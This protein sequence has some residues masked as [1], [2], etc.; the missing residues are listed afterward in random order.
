MDLAPFAAREVC[1][2][3]DNAPA[4]RVERAKERLRANLR[5][6]LPREPPHRAVQL[7]ARR[8]VPRAEDHFV[9]DAARVE[10]SQSRGVAVDQRARQIELL[11]KART[12]PGGADALGSYDRIPLQNYGRKARSGGLACRA[13]SG[14]PTADND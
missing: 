14:R 5:A 4:R 7:F 6:G 8:R 9:L 11:T 2:F 13:R 3:H 10:K 12:Q 1:V